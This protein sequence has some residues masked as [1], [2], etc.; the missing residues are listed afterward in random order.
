MERVGVPLKSLP[1][2]GAVAARRVRRVAPGIAA[3]VSLVLHI[4]IIGSVAL[5]TSGRSEPV[6]HREGLGANAIA[7]TEEAIAT[8]ILIEEPAVG[9]R[10]EDSLEQLASHGV[11]LQNFRLTIVSPEPTVDA[12]IDVDESPDQKAPAAEESTGDRQ[13]QA[14]LFGRYI[15]QIQAR[16]ERAWLR[17]RTP[18]GA[19]SFEC[20]VQV[21]QN[22]RGEVLE[23]TVQRCNGDVS[24]GLSLVHAIDRASPL[25][26]PPDPAVFAETLQLSF[27]S[28]ELIPGGDEEGFEPRVSFTANTPR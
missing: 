6:R 16:I 18:I 13:L 25:P 20:R 22:K 7:S 1:T 2:P 10:E 19:E 23:V 27:H 11:V 12:A 21:L 3:C 4:L 17:P 26:A 15:G 28:A 8:L 14:A 24:W 9:P 5:G